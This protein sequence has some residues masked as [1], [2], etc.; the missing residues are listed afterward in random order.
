MKNVDI[1]LEQLTVEHDLANY[2]EMVNDKENTH[3]I[4]GIDNEIMK[5]EDLK[6]FIRNY[7][8]VLYGIFNENNIHVGNLGFNRFEEKL[9]RCNTGILLSKKYQ[10]HGYA[11]KAFII[12]LNDIFNNYDINKVELFVVKTNFPAIKLYESLG[13]ELKGLVKD[14]FYKNGIYEDSLAYSISKQDFINHH[15]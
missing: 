6:D 5:E 2:V 3:S 13:F 8:G 15:Y 11:F 10:G 14:Q 9:K 4:E 12:G 1:R 7:N